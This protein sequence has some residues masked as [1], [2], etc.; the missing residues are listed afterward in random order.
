MSTRASLPSFLRDADTE[1]HA[2]LIRPILGGL[3]EHPVT[4]YP[5]LFRDNEWF[6]Q[7]PYLLPC[8]VTSSFTALGA[9]LSLFIG[10]DGGPREGAIALPE[11]VDIERASQTFASNVES[12]GRSAGKRISGYFSKNDADAAEAELNLSHTHAGSSSLGDAGDRSRAS[13]AV[14]QSPLPRTFTQQVD[15]ETGGPPSPIESDV[16]IVTNNND[17]S[18]RPR[19][20]STTSSYAGRPVSRTDYRRQ[21]ILSAGSAYGYESRRPSRGANSNFNGTAERPRSQHAASASG[22]SASQYAPDF[23]EIGQ[24]RPEL[25]FAQRFLL[26]NDDAVLSITDLWVAA[27][28]NGEDAYSAMDE[29]VFIDDEEPSEML[30]DDAD[31]DFGGRFGYADVA[32]D[33]DENSSLLQPRHLPPLNFAQRKWSRGGASDAPSSRGA[34][35]RMNRRSSSGTRVPSLYSNTGLV[36]RPMSPTAGLLSPI[37]QV[38]PGGPSA[39]ARNEARP[40]AFDPSLAGI[41][42]SRRVSLHAPNES[43]AAAQQNPQQQQEEPASIWSM[44]PLLIIAHY[45]LM[46]WHSSTFDQ[47]FMAFLVTPYQS[48]GLGLTAAH[49]AE[50]IAAMAFCQMYLQFVFYP[51]A[52]SKFSHLA[53]LRIG[54]CI[55]LP[56]YTL[57]PLLRNFLHP[58]TDITVMSG[59]ILFAAIRY[60]GEESR[61]C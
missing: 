45:G 55:Y 1:V 47:V 59:M 24:P 38:P 11:K 2:I 53:M 44:L 43:A 14:P 34:R 39:A 18:R 30:D 35:P 51:K 41:P 26:A 3:L 36:E 22:I 19:G 40:P 27:A 16:T 49:F 21:G 31:D 56:C 23:E 17:I 37:S 50:L 8:I 20:F 54:L 4:K 60:L 58:S 12:F 61:H 5:A 6:T 57:F 13:S 29:D 25:N 10:P 42:E 9:F 46:S 33:V 28:I 32:S 52:S 48:G 7:Y 15:D